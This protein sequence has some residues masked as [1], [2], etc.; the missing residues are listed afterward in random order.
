MPL[1]SRI[2]V[3]LSFVWLLLGSFVGTLMLLAKVGWL[4]PTLLG[5]IWPHANLLL[6]GFFLQF[7]F[8]VAFWILPRFGGKGTD[9]G[10]EIGFRLA[11]V[12]LNCG[13]ASAVAGASANLP[14]LLAVG[15]VVQ[16]LAAVAFASHAWPRVKE[17][18]A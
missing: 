6:C 13:V 11:I 14:A 9:R 1:W 17:F 16:L 10:A 3:R 2:A 15:H 12:L 7:T 4:S 8:G 18:A 5:L